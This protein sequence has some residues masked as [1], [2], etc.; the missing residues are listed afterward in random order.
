M[1]K[2]L[3]R[4][5]VIRAKLYAKSHRGSRSASSEVEENQGELKQQGTNKKR[6]ELTRLQQ[7]SH[8]Y[9]TRQFMRR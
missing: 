8:K 7:Y 4:N 5:N 2:D 6:R 1:K 9:E 3:R